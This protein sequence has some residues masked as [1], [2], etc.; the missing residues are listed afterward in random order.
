MPNEYQSSGMQHC[1]PLSAMCISKP[2]SV[3]KADN[4][5]DKIMSAKFEKEGVPIVY[6]ILKR[7]T[8][9][10]DIGFDRSYGIY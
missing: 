4:K 7:Q 6:I 9:H 5:I 2:E 3:R 8:L 10:V 1:I